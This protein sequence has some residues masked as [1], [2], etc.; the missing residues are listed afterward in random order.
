MRLMRSAILAVLVVLALPALAEEE[1]NDTSS[2]SE[3]ISAPG[4][5]EIISVIADMNASAN[6]TIQD[7]DGWIYLLRDETGNCTSNSEPTIMGSIAANA[8]ACPGD[9]APID[10]EEINI[11]RAADVIENTLP[12]ETAFERIFLTKP[13]N[14]TEPIWCFITKDGKTILIGAGSGEIL[15]GIRTKSRAASRGAISDTISDLIDT[16]SDAEYYICI[17][18]CIAGC[19]SLTSDTYS[20]GYTLD[21]CISDCPEDCKK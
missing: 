20:P 13:E 18:A 19:H 5:A 6:H 12:N 15:S 4:A 7:I 8:M 11:T 16:I 10:E 1:A 21:N 9:L 3:A 14:S 17:D 2:E